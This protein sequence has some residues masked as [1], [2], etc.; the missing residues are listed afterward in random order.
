MTARSGYR[1]VNQ[2]LTTPRVFSTRVLL[3][4]KSFLL[5]LADPRRQVTLGSYVSYIQELR[6]CSKT[7]GVS[8]FETSLPTQGLRHFEDCVREP[9]R[10][11]IPPFAMERFAISIIKYQACSGQKNKTEQSAPTYHPHHDF[12]ITPLWS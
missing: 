10:G 4:R 3:L 7:N 8:C 12:S 9:A 11:F 5:P 2:R 1:R 6:F